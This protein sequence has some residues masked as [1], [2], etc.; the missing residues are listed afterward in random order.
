MSKSIRMVCTRRNAS[1][2]AQ[3]VVGLDL[4]HG[5]AGQPQHFLH[6]LGA[7]GRPVHLGVRHVMRVELPRRS[8]KLGGVRRVGQGVA[9]AAQAIHKHLKFLSQRHRRGRL[10]VGTRQHRHILPL[11]GESRHICDGFVEQGQHHLFG[12]FN[13][14]GPPC[15]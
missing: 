6:E 4:G 9:L 10:A 8:A 11:H 13:D 12:G 14:S 3:V 5:G 1:H 7:K 15:C 2:H